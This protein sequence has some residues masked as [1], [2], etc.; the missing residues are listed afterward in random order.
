MSDSSKEQGRAPKGRRGGGRNR[1][2][3][4]P[5]TIAAGRELSLLALCHL[6]ALEKPEREAALELLWEQASLAP[7]EE[8]GRDRPLPIGEK[9]VDRSASGQLARLVASSEAVDLAKKILELWGQHSEA[10]DQQIEDISQRWRVARM[11]VT[12]RNVIRLATIELK[13]TPANKR[14]IVGDAVRL[15]SR[16]GSERSARFVNGVVESLAKALRGES[17]T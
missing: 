16:Y 14:A 10:V 12:D 4:G 9:E 15:A 11:D 1:K 5:G 3:K 7:P 13:Y 6:D 17:P 8:P 2:A